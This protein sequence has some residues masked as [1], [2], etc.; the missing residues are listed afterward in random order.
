LVLFFMQSNLRGS[1]PATSCSQPLL[2]LA[3]PQNFR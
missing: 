2:K 1:N 3:P